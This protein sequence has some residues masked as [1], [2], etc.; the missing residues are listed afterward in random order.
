MKEVEIEY[1]GRSFTVGLIEEQRYFQQNIRGNHYAPVYD[2]RAFDYLA[3][4][5][6][7]RNQRKYDNRILIAGPVRSG[8]STIAATWAKR[9]D[10]DIPVE[11]FAFRLADFKKLLNSL[12]DA[13]PEHGIFP[14]AVLDESGV[15]LYSKDWATVWVKSMAKVFQIIGKKRLTMILDLPHKNL[16]AK[17]MLNQM[18]FW[19]NTDD[20]EDLRG[21]AEVRLSKANPW[22]SPYWNPLMGIIYDELK[23]KWWN[24][25]ESAK[26]DFI[27]DYT[28]EE[29]GTVPHRI[30]KLMQQRDAA[31]RELRK[32]HTLREI[33]D[34]TGVNN[35]QVSRI[36]SRTSSPLI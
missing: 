19:V 36:M 23:G 20:D 27:D 1:K 35:A 12:P 11:N 18:R 26:D 31:L 33:E 15:D 17:D 9:I 25:Y 24:E 29:E 5:V 6:I 8:K 10:P 22:T 34:V 21:Y 14:I 13:D 4:R 16:L 7:R 3:W 2:P 30:Q 32:N 28:A